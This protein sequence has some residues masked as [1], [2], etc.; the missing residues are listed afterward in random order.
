MLS[1]ISFFIGYL[2]AFCAV[3]MVICGVI[4]K[5][6]MDKKYSKKGEKNA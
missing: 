2:F 1:I 6:E 4:C 5:R 3:G